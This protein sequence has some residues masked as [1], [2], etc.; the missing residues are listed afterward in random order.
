MKTLT[1]LDMQCIALYEDIALAT[2][3]IY[4][5]KDD[6]D[7]FPY[8]VM[9]A[10]VAD[11][12]LVILSSERD[13]CKGKEA[14]AY[15]VWTKKYDEFDRLYKATRRPVFQYKPYASYLKRSPQQTVYNEECI[16]NII[17]I[18]DMDY[19]KSVEIA[20]GSVFIF[21]YKDINF[22]FIAKAQ[23]MIS[24]VFDN[25]WMDWRDYFTCFNEIVLCPKMSV[26]IPYPRDIVKSIIE[27]ISHD[28]DLP[29]HFNT[30]TKISSLLYEKLR[31]NG[32]IAIT[33]SKN[34]NPLVNFNEQVMEP[35]NFNIES[36]KQIRKLLETT[37]DDL[38]LL[39]CSHDKIIYGIGNPN[40]EENDVKYIFYLTGHM[41]WHMDDYSG[42]YNEG[43]L[44]RYKLGNYYLATDE[45]VRS[46]Y[47][48]SKIHEKNLRDIVHELLYES[49]VKAFDH[50]GLIIISNDAENEVKRLCK[51]KRGFCIDKIEYDKLTDENLKLIRALSSIDGALILDMN[52]ACHGIGLILDGVAL[53]NGTPARGSRYNSAKT[54]IAQCANKHIKAYGIIISSDGY[55][56][57]IA[58]NDNEFKRKKISNKH[59][60]YRYLK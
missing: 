19:Y 55:I 15:D 39:V 14:L 22:E 48:Q 24:D 8:A 51:L 9:V 1:T 50:G 46:W 45:E 37:K 13:I 27:T 25:V 47:I 58:S 34:K 40:D 21:L 54:Y 32:R 41:E 59:L 29:L 2:F 4:E 7:R 44:L 16:K 30:V 35:L 36:A 5:N 31:S 52:G 33:K 28:I 23:L 49:N 26:S 6:H 38:A 17:C 18:R 12:E 20:S 11:D 60:Y 56:D 53:Y 3:G 43:K 42:L 57:I 10:Y